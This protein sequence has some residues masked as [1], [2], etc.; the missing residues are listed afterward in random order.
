MA[1]SN[2]IAEISDLNRHEAM[3]DILQDDGSRNYA[4]NLGSGEN[5]YN[6]GNRFLTYTQLATNPVSNTVQNVIDQATTN[7]FGGFKN[8]KMF[9][10][11]LLVP[12]SMYQTSF[13][14]HTIR[15]SLN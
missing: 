13:L 7:N 15:L 14:C 6:E 5:F 12:S 10:T 3:M 11:D 9:I 1:G 8:K 4:D 2:V